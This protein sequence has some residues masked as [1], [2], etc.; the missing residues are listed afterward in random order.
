MKIPSIQIVFLLCLLI[1]ATDV[2][3][4]WFPTDP[5]D[6]CS[7]DWLLPFPVW[8][9]ELAI[10]CT[11]KLVKQWIK[12]QEE[13]AMNHPVIKKAKEVYDKVVET[14]EKTNQTAYQLYYNIDNTVKKAKTEVI[15]VYIR[16][17]RLLGNFFVLKLE[18][19]GLKI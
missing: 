3:S 13:D 6:P 5:L 12:K 14:G 19:I 8:L 2:E 15:G 1:Y 11:P 18:K 16:G 10:R 17:R 7:I 4:Y 9:G